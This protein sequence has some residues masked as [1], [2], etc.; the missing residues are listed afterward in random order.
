MEALA[1][2][3]AAALLPAF[4]A[5]EVPSELA[6]AT[7]RA[8]GLLELGD[9]VQLA[10]AGWAEDL[11]ALPRRK[12]VL[13]AAAFAELLSARLTTPWLAEHLLVYSWLGR[14]VGCHHTQIVERVEAEAGT[15]VGRVDHVVPV[16]NG[17]VLVAEQA[18]LHVLAMPFETTLIPYADIEGAELK[19][20][21]LDVRLGDGT[22]T[23]ELAIQFEE[24]PDRRR[25]FEWRFLSD[26]IERL[27]F[28]EDYV[29]RHR[30]PDE[31]VRRAPA[32]PVAA[33][34]TLVRGPEKDLA[35]A[36]RIGLEALARDPLDVQLVDTALT[37]VAATVGAARA[38]ALFEGVRDQ[39]VGYDGRYAGSLIGNAIALYA[40]SGQ[41]D[42]A[43]ALAREAWVDEPRALGRL[44]FHN[45]ACVASL[46]EDWGLA[47]AA[48]ERAARF[49]EV[50]AQLDREPDFERLRGR[51]AF[52]ALRRRIEA[53]GFEPA[54]AQAFGPGDARLLIETYRRRPAP[55]L[56]Y[57]L[58]QTGA[59]EARDLLVALLERHHTGS[60]VLQAAFY[61]LIALGD[62]E[63]LA[64]ATRCYAEVDARCTL[65]G[66]FLD[67]ERLARST[68]DPEVFR[69]DVEAIMGSDAP[70]F[71]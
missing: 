51:P 60:E 58:V 30:V 57:G 67:A 36:A 3:A 1:D 7:R 33:I 20:D 34:A 25:D 54:Y 62:P 48:L 39:V 64:T 40:Q 44:F 52:Q 63:S 69:R 13:W 19:D 2:R 66:F 32:D 31:V 53:G 56:L 35:A 24:D 9:E 4:E 11:A 28:D 55:E 8:Q 29:E 38:L 17:V 26:R 50:G 14:P 15:R 46:A 41:L 27:S 42:A 37:A 22:R 59:P 49:G 70:D 18:L 45:A 61:S 5:G 6:I 43:L 12:M 47:V 23:F 10:Y 71:D 65:L 21:A 16:S 68:P